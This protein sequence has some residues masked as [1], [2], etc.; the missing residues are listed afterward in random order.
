MYNIPILFIIFKRKDITLQSFQQIRKI[1]P[2]KL[3]I[4]ADGARQDVAGED[5]QVEQTR[6]AVVDAID[7]NCDV[8]T[9]FRENNI[10]CGMGVYTAINWLFENE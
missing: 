10:G 2:A 7:W 3:Y 6:K 5:L 4:A 1:R 8:K 9:L